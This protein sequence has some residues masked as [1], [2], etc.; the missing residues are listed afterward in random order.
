METKIEEV[1]FEKSEE[2][3]KTETILPH[4]LSYEPMIQFVNSGYFTK[5][6]LQIDRFL[7]EDKTI[8]LEKLELAIILLI[9]YL[10][11][12]NKTDSPIYIHIGGM[13]KYLQKRGIG[14]DNVERITEESSFIIG[15]CSAAAHENALEHAVI[16]RFKIGDKNV[17]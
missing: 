15:F 13:D 16:V 17:S 3:S 5:N 9:E 14:I 10:E 2:N 7:D 12:F 11:F 8:D 1:I 4:E 6:A